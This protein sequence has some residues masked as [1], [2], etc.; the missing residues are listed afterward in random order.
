MNKLIVLAAITAVAF[1]K[2]CSKTYSSNDV[3]NQ[4]INKT[5]NCISDNLLCKNAI[6]QF[7]EVSANLINIINK[8]NLV[9]DLVAQVG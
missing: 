6:L 5:V 7:N 4:Y 1:G 9:L 3:E 8:T 2:G